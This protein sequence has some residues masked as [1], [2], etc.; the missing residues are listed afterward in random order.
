MFFVAVLNVIGAILSPLLPSPK[1]EESE[2]NLYK[3]YHEI[4][5]SNQNEVEQPDNSTPTPLPKPSVST[6]PDPTPI[7]YT[8]TPTPTP[9]KTPTI[10]PKKTPTPSP[11]PPSKP[12]SKPTIKEQISFITAKFIDEYDKAKSSKEI[13]LKSVKEIF[14]KVPNDSKLT[15]AKV[16][17]MDYPIDYFVTNATL[18]ISHYE[19]SKTGFVIGFVRQTIINKL[20]FVP[21]ESSSCATKSLIITAIS[22][23]ESMSFKVNFDIGT[24]QLFEFNLN[25]PLACDRLIISNVETYGNSEF[26]CTPYFGLFGPGIMNM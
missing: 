2:G 6:S 21:M 14:N 4:Q 17:L 25:M 13:I 3:I 20:V 24:P 5:D 15:L 18:K 1:L 11:K 23:K 7:P 9:K 19:S 8:P 16:R 22:E 10:T 26:A 12:P